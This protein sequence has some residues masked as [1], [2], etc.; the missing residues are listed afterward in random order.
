MNRSKGTRFL[1]MLMAFLAGHVLLGQSD[2]DTAAWSIDL[3]DVVVTAQYVPTDS[4]NAL[5]EIKAIRQE[6]IQQRGATN[7]EELLNQEGSIRIRQDLVLGSSMSLLGIDGQNVKIMIDEVPVIGRQGGNINLSQLNLQNIERVEIV[8]GPLSVN[9]GTNA[10]AGVINL[11]TKKDQVNRHQIGLNTQYETRGENRLSLNYGTCLSDQLLFKIN[12]AY[13]KFNGLGPDSLRASVW[14]PKEQWSVDAILN[15][16]LGKSQNLRYAF[17]YFDEN[18]T[19]LGVVR[20]PQFKPYAFDDFYRTQRTDHTLAFQGN[21]SEKY[22]LKTTAGYNQ[23][24]RHKNTYR[25]NFADD[26]QIESQELV[27]GQ[28]DTS[29]FNAIMLRGTLASKFKGQPINFQVGLDLRYDNATGKR[30]QDESSNRRNFSSIGDYAVFSSVRYTGI[31][32]L[33]VETGLRYAYNTRYNAPLVPSI[34]AKYDITPNT[35]IRASY[36]QGFRS[37]DLKELFFRFI[38]INHFIIGN[39]DLRAEQSD[40]VQVGLTHELVEDGARI[41]IKFKGFYNHITDKITIFEFVESPDGQIQPAITESTG[42]FAYFNQNTFKTKGFTNNLSVEKNGL[43]FDFGYSLIGYYNELHTR[44]ANVEKFTYTSEW[45]LSAN[46]SL[47]NQTTRFAAFLRRNDR[48]LTFY[49]EQ[50]DTGNTVAQQR[51]Q[52]GFALLDATINQAIW[53]KRIRVTFG[54]K[55]IFNIRQVN[56]T[57]GGGGAHSG[58]SGTLPVGLG[59]SFFVNMTLDLGFK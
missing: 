37:P 6:V 5:H 52:D 2:V 33:Q 38:D 19:N 49:P 21:L 48:L 50:D 51:I 4:R 59:R 13:D 39:P 34:Q 43:T 12:G 8:E 58:N 41:N 47:P 20:R 1:L 29:T 44:L 56:V 54:V 32:R 22:Y 16:E 11:V 7:L 14:N 25:N 53:D 31:P 26:S 18:V 40:N 24:L 3:D 15:Y 27:N 55:N 45:N 42:Q 28:Q 30:I 36:G 35:A 17:S 23:Y 10:L 46:Y 9:Y 57:G